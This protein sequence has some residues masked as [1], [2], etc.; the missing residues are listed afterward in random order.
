MTEVSRP[1]S[2]DFAPRGRKEQP[3]SPAPSPRTGQGR[4]PGWDGPTYYGRSQLKPAP[5]HNGLVGGYIFLAGLSGSASL[6]STIA[7][8]VGGPEVRGLVRRGRRLAMLAPTIGSALLIKDLH[9]PR[10]FYNMLRVAKSRSPMSIGTWILMGFSVGAVP[11]FLADLLSRLP[12]LGWLRPAARLAQAPAAIGG[13]GLS[14][15]TASLLSSTSSPAWAAAPRALAVR[16]GASSVAAAASA[17]MLGERQPGPRRALEAIAAGALATEAVAAVAQERAYR[18]KGVEQATAGRSGKVE[19]IVAT[20][21][22]VALP[23]AL[24]GVSLLSGR[25]R[26][27]AL[28]EAAAVATLAGSLVLRVSTLGVGDESSTRPE[29]SLRF[30]QPENL[31]AGDPAR[32]RLDGAARPRLA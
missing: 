19:K 12:A 21:L 28:A 14:V 16:F 30:A 27:G 5:F 3:S 29:V 26:S 1:G 9:T 15:Y 17:L 13:A 6:L 10:R 8:L 20:G 25:R 24:F 4:R 18:E 11:A 23:L 22:G 2:P 7:D 32:R 31:P